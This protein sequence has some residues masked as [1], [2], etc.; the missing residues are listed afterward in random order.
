MV[1]SDAVSHE[2]LWG[3]ALHKDSDTVTDSEQ[4]TG[5]YDDFE[6]IYFHIEFGQL[7]LFQHPELSAIS[8]L[9]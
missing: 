5:I 3:Q 8:A 9:H 4:Y 2:V 7:S 1:L 6:Y